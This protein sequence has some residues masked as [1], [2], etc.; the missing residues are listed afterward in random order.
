MDANETL[1]LALD[2][3]QSVRRQ[4]LAPDP[5]QQ[6]FLLSTERRILLNNPL[7]SRCFC[8]F[9]TPI[10]R[11]FPQNPGRLHCTAPSHAR[12]QPRTA[13]LPVHPL[14]ETWLL[15]RRSPPIWANDR[16]RQAMGAGRRDHGFCLTDNR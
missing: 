10:G 13:G 5:W 14:R 7:P 9:P 6:K 2:P 15:S 1:A 11:T 3:G 8:R 4:E 12:H 16:L